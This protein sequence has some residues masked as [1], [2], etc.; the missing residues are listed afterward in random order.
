MECIRR[1]ITLILLPLIFIHQE[2]YESYLHTVD[3]KDII[4][5]NDKSFQ[6]HLLF[7]RVD[8]IYLVFYDKSRKD[9]Y[10]QFK[11]DLYD[12]INDKIKQ[13]FISGQPY[14]VK[15]QWIGIIRNHR[16]Y[17]LDQIEINNLDINSVLLI[18]KLL[19]ASPLVINEIQ[20]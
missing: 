12:D 5:S 16:F 20:F 17:T 18:F 1:K 9:I 13:Q 10:V 3:S 2:N 7:S 6:Y 19:Q 4:Y 11:E 15:I 14:Q 8:S